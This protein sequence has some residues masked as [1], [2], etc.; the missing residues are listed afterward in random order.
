MEPEGVGISKIL[1]ALALSVLSVTVITHAKPAQGEVFNNQVAETKP[2]AAQTVADKPNPQD[3]VTKVETKAAEPAPVVTQAVAPAPTPT[4]VVTERPQPA[5]TGGKDD[6]LA[7][8]GIPQSEWAAVDY[9][10]SHESGWRPTVTNSI[11]AHGLC[12]ALPASKMASAGADYMSNPVTQLRW[13]SSYAAQRYGSW[14][15]AYAFWS[16]N[17]WW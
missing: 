9:I 4:P 13:C 6:W 1:T 7:A 14:W 12:Q 10:V 11:G 8:A 16:S 15:S 2:V 17:R 5:Y 3:L